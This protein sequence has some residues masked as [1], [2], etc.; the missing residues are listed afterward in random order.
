MKKEQYFVCAT[1]GKSKHIDD[2]YK[3]D[4]YKTGHVP[5]CKM[6]V[7]EKQREYYKRNKDK[8]KKYDRTDSVPLQKICF[9]CKISKP[10]EDFYKNL[11]NKD[12]LSTYCKICKNEYTKEYVATHEETKRKLA[13]AQI[14]W[15]ANHVYRRWA[16]STITN[17]RNRNI[18]I[19]ITLDC[20]EELAKENPFCELCG[21]KLCWGARKGKVTFDSPT[22]DRTNNEKNICSDNIQIV[23]HR[24]NAIK[25]NLTMD[26]FIRYCN[27]IANKFK[28]KDGITKI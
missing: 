9:R 6:C 4:G 26:E 18:E 23:C 7:R 8:F 21:R 20:L 19:E 1:C 11:R 24:C 2:F 15:N 10:S 27:M 5:E 12:G 22:L 17:H 16:H 28:K 3:N 14:E 13:E 25:Q